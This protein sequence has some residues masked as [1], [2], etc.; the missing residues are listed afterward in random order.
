MSSIRIGAVTI[1]Q[2]PRDDVVPELY[3]RLGADVEIIQRGAL[4][5][6][7]VDVI[8]EHPP[9]SG[10]STLVSRLVDG[11][12]VAIDKGFIVPRL[13][14]QIRSLEN[15]GIP[16]ILLLCTHKFEEICS[17]ATLLLP[18]VALEEI[19]LRQSICRLGVFTPSED[20]ARA[21]RI[22]W[23]T[24]ASEGVRVSAASPYLG[25]DGIEKAAAAMRDK[26][27]DIAVMDCIGYT[28]GMRSRAEDILNVPVYSAVTALGDVAA[29]VIRGESGREP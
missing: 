29:E 3:T 28:E 27:V 14:E 4:D 17:S 19:V 8:R 5:G 2:S 20:Q 12:E 10:D 13:Q 16:L 15:Q 26:R 18:S 23:R 9:A 22:R 6:V 24:Y 7:S 11:T 1:G 25:G 21:Q